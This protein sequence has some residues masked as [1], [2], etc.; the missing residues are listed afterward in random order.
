MGS[1][2]RSCGLSDNR[3][4]TLGGQQGVEALYDT[5]G[6]VVTNLAL[7]PG[8]TRGGCVARSLTEG[9]GVTA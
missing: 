5:T 3:S 6:V 9:M 1:M 8:D 2:S 4:A 7:G